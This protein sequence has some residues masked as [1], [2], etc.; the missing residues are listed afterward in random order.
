MNDPALAVQKALR[1]RFI[2]TAAVTAL[3]PADNIGDQNARPA[4]S[5]SIVLGD[6]R[7]YETNARIDRSIVR[8]VS[9]IHVW[10]QELSTEGVKEIVGAIRR[11][12][13]RVRPLD[14]ADPDH[15]AGDCR[16]KDTHFLRDANGEMSHAVVTVETWVQERWSVTI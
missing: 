2:A 12:I 3:V 8:V 13:G 7:V 16:I 4:P 5:P 11:A 10:K 9:N 14:L 6:D 15:V 1:A